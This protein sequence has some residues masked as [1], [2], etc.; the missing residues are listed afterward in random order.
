MNFWLVLFHRA[1]ILPLMFLLPESNH[2]NMNCQETS[3]E[4]VEIS[5]DGVLQTVFEQ[6]VFGIIKD[7]AVLRWNDQYQ[8]FIPQVLFYFF[9]I[10]LFWILM[11]S[12]KIIV[13]LIILTKW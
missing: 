11:S 10:F 13:L 2:I 12:M 5:E 6:T 7:I 3:L 9:N 8:Q 4:L 1:V